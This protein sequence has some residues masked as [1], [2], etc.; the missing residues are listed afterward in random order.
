MECGQDALRRAIKIIGSQTKL[1]LKLKVSLPRL[2]HWMNLGIKIPIEH[3]IKIEILTQ[4]EILA[5]DLCVDS[6]YELIAYK[7]FI[8]S[9]GNL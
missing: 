7:K 4:G 9:R 5:E 1:A 6:R 2:N 8:Q 3:A